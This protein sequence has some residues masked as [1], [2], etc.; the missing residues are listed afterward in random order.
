VLKLLILFSGYSKLSS[1]L[2]VW[3]ESICQKLQIAP[4]AGQSVAFDIDTFLVDVPGVVRSLKAS[5]KDKVN[6]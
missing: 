3:K 2:Q 6:V 4:E 5:L 1:K